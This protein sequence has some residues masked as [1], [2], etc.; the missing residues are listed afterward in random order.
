MVFV[1]P[2]WAAAPEPEPRPSLHRW[3][4][5]WERSR[6]RLYKPFAFEGKRA[7][8]R[9]SAVFRVGW[10][11]WTP[12]SSFPTKSCWP[13]LQDAGFFRVLPCADDI[14]RQGVQGISDI[15][16]I[17]GIINRDFADVKAIMAAWLCLHGHGHS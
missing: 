17:P 13:S 8:S 3:L 10:I 2:V 15:I 11:R 1:T 7:C 4:A 9:R 5:R 6:S 12:P 14:L 16:T